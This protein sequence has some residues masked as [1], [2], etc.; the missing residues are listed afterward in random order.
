MRW[1]AILLSLAAVATATDPTEPVE[2]EGDVWEDGLL[3]YKTIPRDDQAGSVVDAG[4]LSLL[5]TEQLGAYG[6]SN[7]C[8]VDDW[9]S[10][11]ITISLC[12]SSKEYKKLWDFSCWGLSNAPL[13]GIKFKYTSCLLGIPLKLP[14]W[15]S[16]I[17]AP[18]RIEVLQGTTAPTVSGAVAIRVC[19]KLD[20]AQQSTDIVVSSL[21]NVNDL[22]PASIKNTMDCSYLQKS[23][24]VLGS[25]NTC[26]CQCPDISTEVYGVCTCPSVSTLVNGV[27]TCPSTSTFQDGQCKCS[28]GQSLVNGKCTCPS[29]STLQGGVCKCPLGQELTSGKCVTT[30]YW[31]SN[32]AGFDCGW[33]S[34]DKSSL[35]LRDDCGVTAPSTMSNLIQTVWGNPLVAISATKVGEAFG[36]TKKSAW[37]DYCGG[38]SVLENQITFSTFGVYDLLMNAV[39]YGDSAKCTGCVAVVDSYPPTARTKCQTTTTQTTPALYSVANLANAISEEVKFTSFYSSDNIA[40]NGAYD[41]TSGA[42]ERCDDKSAKMRDFFGGTSLNLSSIDAKCFGNDFLNR[43]LDTAPS[44]NLLKSCTASD[45]SALQCTRCCSKARKLKEYVYD[46]KCGTTLADTEKKISASGDECGFE[47]CLTVPSTLLVTVKT[48]IKAAIASATATVLGGLLPPVAADSKTIHRT[49]TC[50]TFNKGCSYSATLGSL[51][52]RSL[53][54]GVNI[55]GSYNVSNYVYWRYSINT[56]NWNAWNDSA[57]LTFLDA[58]S[59]V[60]VEAWTHCGRAFQDIFKVILH[61]HSPHNACAA[62]SQMWTE[63]S[64]TPRSSESRMCSYPGSD[65]VMMTFKYDSEANTTQDA[66]SVNGKYTGVK[67]YL[68]LAE[69]GALDQVK[70]TELALPSSAGSRIQISKQ[71]ALELVHDPTTATT[72]DVKVRCDF[73]FTHYN[74]TTTELESCANTFTITDCDRPEL[75][76]TGSEVC[77]INECK[78]PSGTPGPFEACN[79]SVFTTA[80]NSSQLVT[81]VKPVKGECC[82]DCSSTLTCAKLTESASTD[83][84]KRCEPSKPLGA[85]MASA[86]SVGSQSLL[87]NSTALVGLLVASAGCCV[88][89]L[90]VMKH[91]AANAAPPTSELDDLLVSLLS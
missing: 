33:R 90:L 61:P 32:N 11:E 21:T 9:Y 44:V 56:E 59:T 68:K 39:D 2:P 42:N 45:L 89:A 31:K 16:G 1:A 77:K 36:L 84:V 70:E 57:T 52:D 30:C 85:V 69:G 60:F 46:F 15:P 27:C 26:S 14:S 73:T 67:C 38:P 10:L 88:L 35:K 83:G 79:G 78:S 23:I 7:R 53:S 17:C 74:A 40:N 12:V 65:F 3:R 22:V 50:T 63:N 13:G 86:L 25:Y 41:A 55:S 80:V 4:V 54:W 5:E 91:R 43:L 6:S 48:G 24:S 8:D 82:R 76:L 18:P 66:S 62:F 19:P 75:R 51:F 29:T 49:I 81:Q 71:L 34:C 37:K 20:C 47:H 87:S 28:G 72:T 64:P 58:N